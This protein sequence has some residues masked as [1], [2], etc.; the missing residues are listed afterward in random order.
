[1]P[2]LVLQF[3]TLVASSDFAMTVALRFQPVPAC[4]FFARQLQHFVQDFLVVVSK[5]TDPDRSQA[6]IDW[7]RNAHLIRLATEPVDLL[8]EAWGQQGHDRLDGFYHSS[9]FYQ[10][11]K[12]IVAGMS[13]DLKKNVTPADRIDSF[14]ESL[15]QLARDLDRWTSET[16]EGDAEETKALVDEANFSFPLFE[17]QDYFEQANERVRAALSNDKPDADECCMATRQQFLAV[18]LLDRYRKMGCKNLDHDCKLALEQAIDSHASLCWVEGIVN[19][20]ESI[21]W[22][23]Q[24]LKQM[25]SEF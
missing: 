17:A 11:V 10:Q 20:S 7:S 19:H 13:D 23:E 25:T 1:M 4:N 3:S 15:L 12:P 16:E 6:A 21:D 18:L 8:L 24:R 22:R 14:T 9:C 2:K 5:E